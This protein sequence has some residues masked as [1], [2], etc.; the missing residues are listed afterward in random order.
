MHMQ[1]NNIT[2][3]NKERASG[4]RPDL[5]LENQ[6]CLAIYR[7]CNSVTRAYSNA[8]KPL[9]LTYTQMLCMMALW[10]KA[11]RTVTEISVA[12][13]LGKAT[14]TP[15]LMRLEADGLVSRSRDLVDERRVN[16][17]LTARG[18]EMKYEAAAIRER[19]FCNVA[20]SLREIDQMRA[21][22]NRLHSLLASAAPM[23]AA[24]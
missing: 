7:T 18:Y 5:Y 14:I 4:E 19:L 24:A 8:M 2:S 22:M 10:Q 20:I 16:V 12:L 3:L 17:G 13:D 11:P 9:G 6:L 23:P 15:L 1:D 21:D